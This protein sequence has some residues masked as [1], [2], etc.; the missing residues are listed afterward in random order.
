MRLLRLN[1]LLLLLLLLLVAVGIP[2]NATADVH[3]IALLDIV[4]RQAA[5]Y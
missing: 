4:S 3:V 1:R 5:I 2:N